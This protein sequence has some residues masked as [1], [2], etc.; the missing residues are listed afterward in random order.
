MTV[1]R[2][3]VPSALNTR[4]VPESAK[5]AVVVYR[6]PDFLSTVMELAESGPKSAE[7]VP[8]TVS[9]IPPISSAGISARGR[10]KPTVVTLSSEIPG[11]R[12]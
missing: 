11:R 3:L 6:T 2:V 7:S 1:C 8:R 4:I 12:P 10:S 5:N 9:T